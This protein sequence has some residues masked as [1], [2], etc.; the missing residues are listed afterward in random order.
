MSA[1]DFKRNI[2]FAFLLQRKNLLVA[3]LFNAVSV[4]VKR[5]EVVVRSYGNNL[6][7]HLQPCSLI[8][9]VKENSNR[10]KKNEER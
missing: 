2:F 5:V 10:K 8:M 1:W 7:L 6:P 9:V 3:G 4:S